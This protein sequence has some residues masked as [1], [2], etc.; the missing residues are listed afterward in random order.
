MTNNPPLNWA[1]LLQQLTEA[2][3]RYCTKRYLNV[4][5]LC[6]FIDKDPGRYPLLAAGI[7]FRQQQQRIVDGLKRMGW[8]QYKSRCRRHGRVFVV[9]WIPEDE[10]LVSAK[11]EMVRKAET[12]T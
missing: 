6:E 9:P 10:I 12:T 11:Q 4:H 3:N 1:E 5:C 7:T 2:T 8:T